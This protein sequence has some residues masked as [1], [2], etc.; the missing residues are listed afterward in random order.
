MAVIYKNFK[1]VLDLDLWNIG[2]NIL[3]TVGW[4]RRIKC[5]IKVVVRSIT[6]GGSAT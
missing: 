3:C 5:S 2:R 6:I 1:P 4:R